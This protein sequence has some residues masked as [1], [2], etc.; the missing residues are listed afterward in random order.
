MTV[1]SSSL[2]SSEILLNTGDIVCDCILQAG[3]INQMGGLVSKTQINSGGKITLMGGE[4]NTVAINSAGRIEVFSGSLYDMTINSAGILQLESGSAV[5]TT[6]NSD[7]S[8]LINDGYIS[9]TVVNSAG[10]MTIYK[11]KVKGTTVN[12]GGK[13]A[14]WGGSALEIVENGG[15]VDLESYYS[16]T[17]A[18]NTFENKTI[19]GSATVHSA[20]TAKKITIE[21]LG[22]MDVFGGGKADEINILSGGRMYVNQG[23]TAKDV[24]IASGG[25]LQAFSGAVVSNVA[26]KK[27]A[28]ISAEN[29]AELLGTLNVADALNTTSGKWSFDSIEF[30]LNGEDGAP[31]NTLLIDNLDNFNELE[32]IGLII[33]DS[34][35]GEFTYYLAKGIGTFSKQISVYDTTGNLLETIDI[36]EALPLANMESL[37]LERED[38]SLKCYISIDAL[39]GLGRSLISNGAVE[40]HWNKSVSTHWTNGYKVSLSV[41]G[42]ILDLPDTANE[43]LEVYNLNEAEIAW[44]V[45]PA[46]AAHYTEG[47]G[48]SIQGDTS[49]APQVVQAL[50]NAIAKVLL[51]RTFSIWDETYM[52]CNTGSVGDAWTGTNECFGLKGKNKIEDVFVGTSAT[53]ILYLTDDDNGDALFIDDTFTALPGTLSEQQARLAKIESIYAGAGNDLVDLTSHD[54]EYIGNGVAIHGGLGNDIIWANKGDNRLFGDAGDDRLV[55]ASGNDVIVGGIGNDSMHGGGGEDIFCFGGNW[56]QDTIQQLADGKITLWFAQ[57]S[58]DNFDKKTLTYTDAMN[59]VQVTGITYDGI[60]LKFGDDG[61]GLYAQLLAEGAFSEFTSEKIFKELD[62]EMLA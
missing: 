23:A 60:T 62:K 46:K 58:E 34:Y 29:G 38:D 35:E 45:K 4:V 50:D 28:S 32:G 61:S 24:M 53:T 22:Q 9:N 12:P 11:G 21:T 42:I 15:W 26:I 10:V 43:G 2:L 18:S 8:M 49:S 19:N 57:G 30:S 27:G 41:N 44:A 51:A 20:T 52:A 6:V 47:T 13:M 59:S 48:I 25:T 56:G 40:L 39:D 33:S 5:R 14:I 3:E 36:G 31:L 37:T 17:F 16:L 55:G 1:Y 54:F 7:G